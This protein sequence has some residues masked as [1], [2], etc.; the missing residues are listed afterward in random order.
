LDCLLLEC[1]LLERSLLVSVG[2]WSKGL[3][4]VVE[5]L[6]MSSFLQ[7]Y[8]HIAQSLA[9]VRL[10]IVSMLVLVPPTVVTVGRALPATVLIPLVVP[11]SLTPAPSAIAIAVIVVVAIPPIAE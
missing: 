2:A 11:A 9:E 10:L 8:L 6:V 7:V 5:L 3:R 4:L 1:G